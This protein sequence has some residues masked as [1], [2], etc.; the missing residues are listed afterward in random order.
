MARRGGLTSTAG[1]RL[2]DARHRNGLECPGRSAQNRYAGE[3]L[4]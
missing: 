4:R 1:P 2:A 3:E